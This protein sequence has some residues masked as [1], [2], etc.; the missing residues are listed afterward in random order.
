MSNQLHQILDL[1]GKAK[2]EMGALL[3]KD[4][5]NEIKKATSSFVVGAK[6]DLK[7][8]IGDRE[9]TK[10]ISREAKK[11]KA[12]FIAEK[13]Q[14]EKLADSLVKKEISKTKNFLEKQKQELTN[15]QS[16]IEEVIG[17]AS[18]RPKKKAPVAKVK[19]KVTSSR[20][21]E[22]KSPTTLSAKNPSIT[23]PKSTPKASKTVKNT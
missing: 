13:K 7:K 3:K 2:E 14:W 23:R 15:L 17:V 11:L 1:L 18:P 10:D 12:K 4:T 22:K 21:A 8:V 9:I 19:S 20:V 5:F 16:K 6:K